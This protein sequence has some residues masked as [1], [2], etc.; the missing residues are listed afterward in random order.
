MTEN[1]KGDVL[2]AQRRAAMLAGVYRLLLE[3]GRARRPVGLVGDYRPVVD[4]SP[5]P[6]VERPTA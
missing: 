4:Q 6:E 1:L 5:T 3:K 2:L